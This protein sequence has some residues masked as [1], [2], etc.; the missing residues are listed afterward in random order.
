MKKVTIYTKGYCPYCKRAVGI[1]KDAGADFEE[2]DVSSDQ[3]TYSKIKSQTGCQTVP[4]VFIGDEFIGGFDDLN[5]I[6]SAGE[7]DT[8]LGK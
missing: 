7:L 1:L 3:A 6:K 8:K 4:Q 2:I 5:A